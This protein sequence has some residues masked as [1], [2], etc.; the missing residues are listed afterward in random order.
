LKWK[1]GTTHLT[2]T[3]FQRLYLLIG[4][5]IFHRFKNKSA[6]L[7]LLLISACGMTARCGTPD[8]ISQADFDALYAEPLSPP[9]QALSVYH[10]G[11]SLVAKDMPAM[12]AQMAGAGHSYGSQLG[13]GSHLRQHWDPEIP[14]KG[15]AESNQHP[16]YREAHEAMA[17]GDYDAVVLTEAVEIRQTIK[18]HD[19]QRYLG[20]WAKS[21]WSGNP[22]TR[23]YFYETWH[24]HDD[25]EG[26]IER[27]DLDL[28][29]YW[30]GEILR[31]ALARDDV[32]QPIYVI[33]GGQ[34]MAAF[35]RRV[36]AAGGIGPIKNR[37][38]LFKDDIHFNDYGA[39]L[40][41][42]THYAV[43]YGRS[44]VGLPHQLTLARGGTAAD[45]GAEAALAMQETVWE[46]VTSYPPTGVSADN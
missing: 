2:D 16:Q 42:L 31:R 15:F 29:R 19:P 25:P 14:I 9:Q 18:Y 30:E 45:P 13:W 43:L 7:L 17:S 46:V 32:T 22:D 6:A 35:A 40:I 28:E 27:I 34:V 37:R 1:T 10:L 38:D 5:M 20:D 41:A 11:H 8:P 12:L 23:V 36:E 39:Y 33:P 21:A 3:V 24:R 44:P 26:W 4:K